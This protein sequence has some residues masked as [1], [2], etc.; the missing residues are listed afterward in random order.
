MVCA[1]M[2]VGARER[3]RK[4]RMGVREGVWVIDKERE[5]DKVGA[6]VGVWVTEK[7]RRRKRVNASVVDRDR[8]REGAV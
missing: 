4:K 2:G 8:E 1:L 5:R 3:E 6:R 7:A